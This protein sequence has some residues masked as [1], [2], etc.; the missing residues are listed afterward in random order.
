M[1][2]PLPL[3]YL[4][5]G[6]S[7]RHEV[8]ILDLRLSDSLV[9]TISAWKPDV[10]GITGFTFHTPEMLS[11]A[12]EVKAISRDIK[13]VVGGHHATFMPES[14]MVPDIDIIGRWQCEGIMERMLD[15]VCSEHKLSRIPGLI[16]RSK[17][18]WVESSIRPASIFPNLIP[19]RHLI[20]Q[21]A[22][23]YHVLGVNCSAMQMTRGCAYECTFCDSSKFFERQWQHRDAQSIIT[24]LSSLSAPLVLIVDD[25]IAV[26]TTFL[27]N[28][29]SW[30]VESKIKKRYYISIGANE[31]LR[32]KEVLDK[33]FELGLLIASIGLERVSDE[34]ISGF[35]K[36]TDVS[37]NDSAVKY[38]HS[39]GGIVIGAFI[40]LPT[41]TTE[42]FKR[43]EDYI[44]TREIDVPFLCILTPL[45]GT[46]I[47]RQYCDK[48][49]RTFSKYDLLHAVIPTTIPEAEFH[50]HFYHLYTSLNVRRLVW[51]MVRSMGVGT[52]LLK[53]PKAHRA[54]QKLKRG[55]A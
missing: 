38:W 21:H 6:V 18:E 5:A 52:W 26:N 49:D 4:A 41:D 14:F 25:N 8:R 28:V 31:V 35:R 24:E 40:T 37:T 27:K 16:Y 15:S 53:L 45:P 44:R 19:S 36:K 47:W 12:G 33:W 42:D 34:G 3:E 10:V 20:K 22:N 50:R 43:L 51:K 29:L 32:N 48:L 23:K 9:S 30:L 2:E 39:R 1:V 54:F 46:D 13:V 7:Q 11:L 17:T 55:E